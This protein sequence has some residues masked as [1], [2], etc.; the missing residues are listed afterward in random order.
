MFN[1][2]IYIR[3]Q[4][5]VKKTNDRSNNHRVCKNIFNHSYL[6]K[7]H[8]S[9]LNYVWLEKVH[10]QNKNRHTH[11]Q[12]RLTRIDREKKFSTK[13][14]KCLIYIY[15]YIHYIMQLQL[16]MTIPPLK[17]VL[18]WFFFFCLVFV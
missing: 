11:T 2:S 6:L 8:K 9:Q 16:Q 4:R 14:S 5:N 3:R 1:S 13:L 18:L 12:N 15:I 17:N 7:V 10:K